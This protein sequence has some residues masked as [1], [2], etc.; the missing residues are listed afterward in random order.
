MFAARQD[1]AVG[2]LFDKSRGKPRDLYGI[3]RQ[4][5]VRNDGPISAEVEHWSKIDIESGSFEFRRDNPR[6]NPELRCS[7]IRELRHGWNGP[8]DLFQPIDTA[9]LMIN[10]EE[11]LDRQHLMQP[12]V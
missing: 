9:A 11:R 6:S 7:G 1:S 3:T 10:S 2:K 5:S 4:A 12:A 8:K